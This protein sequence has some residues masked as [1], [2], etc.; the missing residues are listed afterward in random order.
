[1]KRLEKV[2]KDADVKAYINPEI[3]EEHKNKSIELFKQGDFPGAIKE[4][5]EGLRR[6]PFSTALYSK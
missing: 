3:E 5:E 6:D 4:F 1:M 2:N